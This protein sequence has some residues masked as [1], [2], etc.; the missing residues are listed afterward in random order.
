MNIQWITFK[1][2]P[3]DVATTFHR[4]LLFRHIWDEK[5]VKRFL[6]RTIIIFIPFANLSWY[7]YN[8]TRYYFSQS[9]L[10]SFFYHVLTWLRN[11]IK[12]VALYFDASL[13]LLKNATRWHLQTAIMLRWSTSWTR[14]YEWRV[15]YVNKITLMK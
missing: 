13:W 10:R 4:F 3:G 9:I 11:A 6:I 12:L 1:V 15:V 5:K 14:N 7:M 2:S 8:S